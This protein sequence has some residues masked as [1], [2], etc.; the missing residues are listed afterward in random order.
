MKG[1]LLPLY[2]EH[3]VSEVSKELIEEHI[4]GCS[5][6]K[7]LFENMNS[8]LID[9]NIVCEKEEGVALNPFK[10]IKRFNRKMLVITA[11]L[12]GVISLG[13]LT[14]VLYSIGGWQQVG[15]VFNVNHD[16]IISNKGYTEQLKEMLG[17][18]EGWD[19]SK[20]KIDSPA[21]MF[22]WGSKND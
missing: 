4:A 15:K 8:T 18:K 22:S 11:V 1:D 9:K 14:S 13:G 7:E 10:K 19:I 16:K 17:E 6:C 2:M 21:Q 5:I 12:S 3:Q 20:I